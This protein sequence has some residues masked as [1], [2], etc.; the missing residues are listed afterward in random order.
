GN[1]S[2]QE[3]GGI[4]NGGLLS[5]TNSTIAGNTAGT[6]FPHSGGGIFFAAG[7]SE[8]SIR[9]TIIA[10]NAGSNGPDLYG[11]LGSPGHNLFG[12]TQGGSG[13]DA[14]DLLNVDPMLG[15][16][17]DNGGPTQT[18][19]LLPGSPAIDAG[20][21]TG[22]PDWDQRGPGFPRIVNG[23]IDIGAFEVQN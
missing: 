3:G 4:F 22:A 10:G 5:I 17:Q 20:D 18:M 21:N 15:P 9:D 1:V 6:M 19:A 13:F 2:L 14:T 7:G 23:V 11:A 8:V 12:N 16:L